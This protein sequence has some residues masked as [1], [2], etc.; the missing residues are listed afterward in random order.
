[1]ARR[2]SIPEELTDLEILKSELF[3]DE[4]IDDY[5]TTSEAKRGIRRSPKPKTI[6]QAMDKILSTLHKSNLSATAIRKAR[7]ALD[8]LNERLGL[9]DIQ[10]IFLSMLCDAGRPLDYCQFASYLACHRITLIGNDAELQQLVRKGIINRIPCDHG[11]DDYVIRNEAI[12]AYQK[13]EPYVR[14]SFENLSFDE[15]LIRM[16]YLI[17]KRT[18]GHSTFSDL[19][20]DI[21]ALFDCNP[22]LEFVQEV[23]K[24]NLAEKDMIT[25]LVCVNS[26]VEYNDSMDERKLE[27]TLDGRGDGSRIIS[28]LKRGNHTLIKEGIIIQ[29]CDEGFL[30]SRE[31]ELTDKAKHILLKNYEFEEVETKTDPRRG[32]YLHENIK[33][34][35]LFYNK[36]ED[37][38]ISRLTDLLQDKNLKDIQMRLEEKGMRKGFTCLFYGAPGTGKTET[39]MQLAR[40]TGRDIF[41]VNIAGLRDKYVGESE[42]NIKAIFTRYKNF[43]ENCDKTPILLFNEADAI[44]NKRT[45][46]VDSSVDKM[47]NA[48]Q[49]I[50]LNELEQL[51]GI[52]IATTNL[53]SNLDSAFERR[54][55]YKVEFKKPETQVKIEIWKAMIP[56]LSDKDAA[57]LAREFNFSGGEIEN[58]SRKMTVDSILYGCEPSLKKLREYCSCEAISNKNNKER[59]KVSGFS[60]CA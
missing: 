53:T 21:D 3:D 31:Y 27:R 8:Y 49:N 52:L 54:F 37:E 28:Q 14:P 33:E 57:A 41:V 29:S 6:I 50:I 26:L 45:E 7:P 17:T 47:D 20:I 25:L 42:K 22:K 5:N 18:N 24:L 43:C 58:I 11:E 38:Q 4:V 12:E 56:E 55:L 15:F 51:E 40:K 34:K 10:N 60:L 35:A 48:M 39:V 9:S 2:N 19:M 46:N 13:N 36:T 32:L 59:S 30:S 44:I 16:N 23:R 1:M